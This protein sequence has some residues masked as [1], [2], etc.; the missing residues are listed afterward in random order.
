MEA[1]LVSTNVRYWKH[2]K[3]LRF[4]ADRTEETT[5]THIRDAHRDIYERGATLRRALQKLER[6]GAVHRD[7]QDLGWW[8][9]GA[10]LMNHQ[11]EVCVWSVTDSGRRLLVIVDQKEVRGG[12]SVNADHPRAGTRRVEAYPPDS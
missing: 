5:T 1:T 10:K 8:I 4:I 9:E 7:Y 3:I 12:L 11:G 6:L 2:M